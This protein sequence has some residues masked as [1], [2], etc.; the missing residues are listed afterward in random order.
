MECPHLK[1]L[2]DQLLHAGIA[3][4]Q[5]GSTWGDDVGEFAYFD[6][7][8]ERQALRERLQLAECVRDEEYLGTHMGSEYGFYCNECKYGVMG[9]HPK[10]SGD[11]D[12]FR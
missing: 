6:C 8:L 4:T 9:Y 7:I 11:R 10:A 3:E 12:V 2:E 5:R 1:E